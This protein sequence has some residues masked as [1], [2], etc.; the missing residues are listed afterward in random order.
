MSQGP[1]PAA[2]DPARRASSSCGKGEREVAP[3]GVRH[4]NETK[5][6]RI[7]RNEDMVA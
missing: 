6:V 4:C 7:W 5:E 1:A 2:G 3:G